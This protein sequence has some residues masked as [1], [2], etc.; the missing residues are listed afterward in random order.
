[1]RLGFFGLEE[2]NFVEFNITGD[3][4]NC[5]RLRE[6]SY[7]LGSEVFNLFISVFEKSNE[8]YEYFEPTKYNAR[9]IVVLRNELISFSEKLNKIA[10][11]KGFIAFIEGILWG[12]TFIDGIE[13]EDPAWR[14]HWENYLSDLR[15]V[16]LEMIII[17][18]RCIDEGRILWL[19]G[20]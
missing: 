1:M 16:N 18:E 12:K 9:K 10:S 15:K 8:L 19:V 20:Y 5:Q 6:E 13:K 2:L 17:V 14:E 4:L 3:D 7:Y 11:S